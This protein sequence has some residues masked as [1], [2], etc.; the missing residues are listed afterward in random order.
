MYLDI[1]RVDEGDY[2]K[3]NLAVKITMSNIM[4]KNTR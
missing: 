1:G 2:V 3:K 4:M